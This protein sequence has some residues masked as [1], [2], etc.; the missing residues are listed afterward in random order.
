MM[1]VAKAAGNA[2]SG[3]IGGLTSITCMLT[4]TMHTKIL[5]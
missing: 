3:A 1:G 4:W 2:V 5:L